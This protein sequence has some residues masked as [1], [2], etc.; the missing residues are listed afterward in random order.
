MIK[1]QKLKTISFILFNTR[2]RLLVASSKE[3]MQKL[4]L[5]FLVCKFLVAVE[6]SA[7]EEEVYHG[8]RRYWT[9]ETIGKTHVALH[10]LKEHV[11]LIF[12]KDKTFPDLLL[13]IKLYSPTGNGKCQDTRGSLEFTLLIANE[14]DIH[15]KIM[16]L[17]GPETSNVIAYLYE[18][19]KRA[20]RPNYYASS[21][22]DV[23][24]VELANSGRTCP[25]SVP[26]EVYDKDTTK[27][28]MELRV[29]STFE[30]QAFMEL[31]SYMEV[32]D[33]K[34][35]AK[36]TTALNGT[37]AGHDDGYW[38]K[39]KNDEMLP[40]TVSFDENKNV[41]IDI[42]NSTVISPYFFRIG[43]GQPI[44]SLKLNFGTK[45]VN[46]VFQM[47]LNLKQDCQVLL[48]LNQN[49]FTFS[50]SLNPNKDIQ[51]LI[52]SM[53][54][55]GNKVF[56]K[57]A[58]PLSINEFE[59]CEISNPSDV[60]SDQFVLQIAPLENIGDCEKAELIL[61]SSDVVN[62][63]EVLIDRSRIVENETE[64][65]E[66]STVSSSTTTKAA[67]VGLQWWWFFIIGVLILAAV[68]AFVIYVCFI[69]PRLQK[70]K[71]SKMPIVLVES[72]DDEEERR[73]IRTTKTAISPESKTAKEKTKTKDDGEKK[74]EKK[75]PAKVQ[76]SKPLPPPPPPIPAAPRKPLPP[77]Q[78]KYRCMYGEDG[79]TKMDEPYDYHI[80]E[81]DQFK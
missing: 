18:K 13:K 12:P 32:E 11:K 37:F 57:V 58:S 19:C 75:T 35:P 50:T 41:K 34:L 48:K 30:C 76:P 15:G 69:R 6:S 20:G 45:C 47:Y 7:T 1:A 79:F 17:M 2:R 43:N 61:S 59:T 27:Y 55:G 53:V 56:V 9:T 63:I 68:S 4:F 72:V 49:G 71:K 39:N 65:T 77:R 54:F 26:F 67:A 60:P 44:P 51:G 16:V 38:W 24:P 52:S 3:E 81:T 62:E 8:N 28:F 23:N 21:P 36:S 29:S 64:T 40:S 25:N 42:L 10:I 70:R 46:A 80:N 31:P 74:I 66:N 14:Y 22:I 5:F 78:L 33:I 73:N